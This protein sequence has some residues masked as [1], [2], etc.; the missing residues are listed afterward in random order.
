MALNESKGNMYPFVSHTWNP[1]KGACSHDCEYCYMKAHGKQNPIRL[2]AKEMKVSLGACNKIFVGS[3]TDMFAADV[4]AVWITQVLYRCGLFPTNEYLFQTKN[5][6]RY[7]HFLKDIPLGSTL[8]VT[9][10]T[11]DEA[12]AAKYSKAPPIWKRLAAISSLSTDFKRMISIEPVMR[13]S[14]GFY[15]RICAAFPDRVSIG[16]DSKRHGL[17]EPTVY[18]LQALI[19]DLQK[20]DA[21]I[22][23]KGNLV[24]IFGPCWGA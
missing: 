10:E 1:I 19:D 22:V 4:P 24:R 9:I 6:D 18:E 16:A 13:F 2:D 11:D 5:P 7:Y 17:P 14:I 12:L 8:A 23:Q 3:S 20:T 21:E 15:D